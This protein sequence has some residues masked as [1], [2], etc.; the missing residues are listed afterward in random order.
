[1]VLSQ[2][3]Q[4]IFI[5]SDFDDQLQLKHIEQQIAKQIITIPQIQNGVIISSLICEI[6]HLPL[7]GKY[8]CFLQRLNGYSIFCVDINQEILLIDKDSFQQKQLTYIEFK[9]ETDFEENCEELFYDNSQFLVFCLF[10]NQIRAKSINLQSITQIINVYQLDQIQQKNCKRKYIKISD[11]NYFLIHFQCYFWDILNFQNNQITLFLNN[12]IAQHNFNVSISFISNFQI[13]SYYLQSNQL[14][15]LTYLITDI[16]YHHLT[17]KSNNLLIYNYF[18]KKENLE[19]IL[20]NSRCLPI[21]FIQSSDSKVIF[22][23]QNI[24]KEFDSN[25]FDSYYFNNILFLQTL[26]GLELSYNDILYQYLPI[27][28]IKLHISPFFNL[29]YQID[30]N[31]NQILLFQ[32]LLHQNFI[33]P[34]KKYLYE[35]ADYRIN[36]FI[37]QCYYIENIQSNINGIYSLIFDNIC[38][39]VENLLLQKYATQLPKQY[40]IQI[41]HDPKTQILNITDQYQIHEKCTMINENNLESLK[42]NIIYHSQEFN[43]ILMKG[44]NILIFKHCDSGH[45][46][47]FT[48]FEQQVFFYKTNIILIRK[49]SKDIRLIQYQFD[50]IKQLNKQLKQDILNILQFEQYILIM[51]QNKENYMLIDIQAQLIISQSQQMFDYL[52]QIKSTKIEENQEKQIFFYYL[53]DIIFLQYNE[54]F[55]SFFKQKYQYFVMKNLQ[56]I[57]I[58]K[59]IINLHQILAVHQIQDI[60]YLFYL[61]QEELIKIYEFSFDKA[62]IVRPLIYTINQ[63]CLII[64]VQQEQEYQ[65]LIFTIFKNKNL[66]L[67]KTI[68]IS[69]LQFFLENHYLYYFDLNFNIMVYNIKYFEFTLQNIDPLQIN[70][71]SSQNLS[72]DIISLNS[73][74]TNKT[75]QIQLKQINLCCKLFAIDNQKT[76]LFKNNKSLKIH[77]DTIFLGCIDQ[78]SLQNQ[79]QI[80][81]KGPILLKANINKNQIFSNLTIKTLYFYDSNINQQNKSKIIYIINIDIKDQ[82]IVYNQEM[83]NFLNKEYGRLLDINYIFNQ[84]LIIMF[85]SHQKDLSYIR[86][87]LKD[88]QFTLIDQQQLQSKIDV[89]NEFEFYNTRNLI[90]FKQQLNYELWVVENQSIDQIKNTFQQS[91]VLFI[92]NTDKLYISVQFT[93][94]NKEW[95][96]QIFALEQLQIQLNILRLIKRDII[97][98]ELNK[99]V[100]LQESNY[101]SDQQIHLLEAQKLDNNVQLIMILNFNKFSILGRFNISL[102]NL[103][104]SFNVVKVIRT[105]IQEGILAPKYYDQNILIL[106][107]LQNYVYLFDL[108]QQKLMCDYINNLSIINFAMYAINSTHYLFYYVESDEFHIGE[109]DYELEIIDSQIEQVSITLISQNSVSIAQVDL[110]ILV[111]QDVQ[112]N[113]INI[114]ITILI[115]IIL[116]V[117]LKLNC[118]RIKRKQILNI[119]NISSIE[120]GQSNIK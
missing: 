85:I 95:E 47:K 29:F 7:L 43:V 45:L 68:Q 63:N 101:I 19:K 88:N 113:R 92:Q 31:T 21:S 112:I 26:K 48:I 93:Q 73:I 2:Q 12:E 30:N 104:Y 17:I 81:L 55:I 53:G 84:F 36:Y 86:F 8:F 23:F 4:N 70:A 59:V 114:I 11:D 82:I 1:M 41:Q 5:E 116:I 106:T 115:L 97:I 52:N 96:I 20:F 37:S 67:I 118:N 35:I 89:I 65:L 99:Y 15:Q 14:F 120:L 105:K 44:E 78:L 94:M 46:F 16:G 109:I 64:A 22:E 87:L 91:R 28:F 90:I 13:C 98:S 66:Q 119:Q 100:V 71:I 6:F 25:Y 80:Y 77:L 10:S 42:L 24:K 38:Q 50:E 58:Q 117:L 34:T 111:E 110:L 39:S 103:D 3:S 60:L 49:N 61:N 9:V 75:I 18:I 107:S 72:F 27:N 33:Q 83:K 32:F 62:K 74:E 69:K 40:Y 54:Q 76:L 56:I 102:I 79:N 57:K 108:R 51:T